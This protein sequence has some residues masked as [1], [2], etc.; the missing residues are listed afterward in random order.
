MELDFMDRIPGLDACVYVGVTGTQAASSIP[1]LL[2]GDK[3]F[4]GKLVDT[5]P[6]TFE[7]HPASYSTWF[8]ANNYAGSDIGGI[9]YVEGIYVGYKWFETADH[10]GV[11]NNVDRS[12]TYG[13]HAKGYNGVVQYPFGYGL[14]YSDFKWDV[15]SVEGKTSDGTIIHPGDDFV[16]DKTTFT[17]KVRVTN[18]S[19]VPGR[20]VVELYY[21]PPY[22][23]GQIEKS[24]V[25]LLAF[26]KTEILEKNQSQVIELT[27][28]GYDMASY[29]CYDKNNNN[30]SG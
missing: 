4:S 15:V 11:Y 6:Y 9:D 17:V 18:T 28:A 24:A 26:G 5:I 20:D 25:N 10:E 14:S 19:E 23:K 8:G 2:Y 1:S 30:H 7:D 21:T 13:E 12:A 27:F 3:S 29:D 22:Y 16:N